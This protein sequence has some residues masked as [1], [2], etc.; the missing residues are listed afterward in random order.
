MKK[1]VIYARYSSYGQTEQSIE[2]Q[3]RVCHKFAEEQDFIILKEYVDRARTAQNDLRPAFQAMLADSAKRQFDYVIVYA[4]DRFA[5][6][7]GDYGAD[8]RILRENGVKLLS[9]TETIGTNADGSE[10][11]GGI[12][13]EGILVALAKYYSRELS[14]KVK[15][16]QFETLQKK[17]HLGGNTLYG[18]KIE[19]KQIL[20]HEEQAAVVRTMFDMYSD[21]KTA[22]DIAKYLNQKGVTNIK[23]NP[24]N[25][26]TIMNMLKNKKYIGIFTYGE[27]VIEN[28]YP[29]IID[30]RMFEIVQEKIEKNKR[31]PGRGKAQV[32]YLLSGKL[33]CGECRT[34]MTGETG[35]SHT[36]KIHSYYK[37]FGKKKNKDSCKKKSYPKKTLE[38]LVVNTTLDHFLQPEIIE[39]VTVDLLKLQDEQRN[40]AELTLLRR[41]L[42]DT[43]TY[44]QNLLNTIKRGVVS[45]AIQEEL[46]KLE[47]QKKELKEK[48]TRAEYVAEAY[49]TREL[50][51]FWFDQFSTFNYESEEARQYLVNYLIN[52]IILFDDK[53]IIIYNHNGKNRT[54]IDFNTIEEVLGS[55]LAQIPAPKGIVFERTVLFFI[56]GV[57]LC[58]NQMKALISFTKTIHLKTSKSVK[59]AFSTLMKSA[60]MRIVMNLIIPLMKNPCVQNILTDT[61]MSF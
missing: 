26:N 42:K 51:D 48:I 39:S 60:A 54:E 13:T 6:D 7:D 52:K 28:Y 35:T 3:L 21:G 47:S 41:E 2:G 19:N 11:L 37:C 24:F 57:C 44:I 46:Q 8:K 10:N 38:D 56:L 16:G 15:R 20:I 23:G 33:Y 61:I 1:A 12:L 43:E 9:A 36:G 31:S 49:L 25:P 45:D 5:R 32:P 29:P 55:N 59:P 53:L 18:Y 17:T 50:I 4:V 30:K 34:Q 40:T 22:F 58:L 27:H 14:K